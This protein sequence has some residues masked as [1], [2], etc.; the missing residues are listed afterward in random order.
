MENNLFVRSSKLIQCLK[1]KLFQIGKDNPFYWYYYLK[2]AGKRV[3]TK[4]MAD[5]AVNEFIVDNPEYKILEV[6]SRRF[7]TRE[8]CE[9]AVKRIES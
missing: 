7:L 2:D 8:V 9:G 6:I 4:E 5:K 3:Q 1:N